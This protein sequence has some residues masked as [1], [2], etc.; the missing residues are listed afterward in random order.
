M[1][2][3]S[4]LV[5]MSIAA[6]VVLLI[7]VHSNS[8][9][10]KE[11]RKGFELTFILVIVGT[12]CEW[13]SSIMNGE[14]FLPSHLDI[15]LHILVK[16][17]ELSIVPVMPLIC[18]KIVFEEDD[19]STQKSKIPLF[20]VIVQAIL[21][22]ISTR[23]GFIFW[24]DEENFYHH[25]DFYFIYI[26]TFIFTAAYMFY[27]ALEFSKVYQNKNS[28][29]LY[30]IF[31]FIAFGV[32]VQLLNPEI[33]SCWLTISISGIFMYAYYN[34]LYQY[35]DGLTELLNQHSYHNSLMNLKKTAIIIKFD[36]DD[37]KS[38]NDTWGHDIGD[39]VLKVIGKNIKAIYVDY[40]KCYR[41]GGDEF[42]VILTKDIDKAEELS[43]A[44]SDSLI[45][46]R[47]KL[48]FFPFVSYGISEVNPMAVQRISIEEASKRADEELY[49]FK[50]KH[51]EKRSNHDFE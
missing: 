48:P 16:C 26:V 19:F 6:M 24:V 45:A 28:Y 25:G 51:K 50:K 47:E 3:Y 2:Y 7:V 49:S 40:G 11:T 5:I 8:N 27:N 38:V 46:E 34:E 15:N 13:A 21:E 39:K 9:I 23:A 37:F 1:D 36:V 44:F 42:A 41:V 43:D 12:F 18:S 4:T 31:A 14:V 30:A 32:S 10:A 20:V 29:E 35:V 33:K 17:L 22:I